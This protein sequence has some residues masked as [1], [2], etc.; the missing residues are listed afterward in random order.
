MAKS[1]AG[2][3][4]TPPSKAYT[5]AFQGAVVVVCLA[6]WFMLTATKVVGADQL[7]SPSHTL[8][9]I[10][11][12]LSKTE[13]LHDIAVTLYELVI[14][15]LIA[16][17]AGL[18]AGFILAEYGRHHIRVKKLIETGLGTALA[19]PKFI[20]LPILV[21]LI[22]AGYW[23]KVVYAAADGLIVA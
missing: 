21:L 9:S 11:Q 19:T 12:I 23:E 1:A 22:G 5:I 6:A 2:F 8:G 3:S 16:A 17:I 10:G 13:Y 18:G 7:P 15:F 14:S 4:R 20:F